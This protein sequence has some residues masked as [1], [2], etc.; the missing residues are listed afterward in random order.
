MAR[1]RLEDLFLL[2]D[3]VSYNLIM[4]G[5]IS[6]LP[7]YTREE[8]NYFEVARI[9]FKNNYSG[10]PTRVRPT[11]DSRLCSWKSFLL[12]CGME[13]THTKDGEREKVW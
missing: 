2:G 3:A 11:K 10:Q 13:H 4:T 1:L 9:F 12:G 8:K 7:H 5:S 6:F